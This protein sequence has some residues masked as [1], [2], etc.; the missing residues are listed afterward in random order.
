MAD[1]AT[2]A[3]DLRTLTR[4]QLGC[5]GLGL[6]LAQREL[7]PPLLPPSTLPATWGG[8]AGLLLLLLALLLGGRR[9]APVGIP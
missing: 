2:T 7:W 4:L 9:R 5:A 8:G 1:Q 3:A 6:A